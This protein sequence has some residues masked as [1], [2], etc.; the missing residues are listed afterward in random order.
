MKKEVKPLYRK[1]NTRT[2]NVH[3]QFGGDAKNDRNTKIGT[4]K[5]MKK[6]VHRGLDYTPLF[7]FLLSKVGKNW[8]DVYSEAIKRVNKEEP[9]FYMVYKENEHR[10]RPTHTKRSYMKYGENSYFSMLFVDDDNILRVLDPNFNNEDL[11]PTCGCCTHTF[12]GK[13]FINKY[14]TYQ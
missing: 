11:K 13:P 4:R 7:K 5:T 1:D 9:I 3:H 10:V 2:R 14:P 12:N 6:D 8:D